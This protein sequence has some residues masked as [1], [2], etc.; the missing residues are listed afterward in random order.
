ME[1][2]RFLAFI[3]DAIIALLLFIPISTILVLTRVE[4]CAVMLPWIIWIG[5]LCKD[6]FGGRSIGKRLMG[7]QI[8]DKNTFETPSPYKCILRNLTYLLGLIDIAT[9]FYKKEWRRLGDY[10]IN[11]KVIHHNHIPTK[12]KYFESIIIILCVFALFLCVNFLLV[13]WHKQLGLD[14]LPTLK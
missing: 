6:C 9:M 13:T 14:L 5:L 1:F 10:V 2:K 8:V 4:V 3:I 7:Y 11:T 12:I